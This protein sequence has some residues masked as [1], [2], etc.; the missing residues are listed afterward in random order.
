MITY[1]KNRLSRGGAGFKGAGLL[2]WK[3]GDEGEILVLLGKRLNGVDKGRWSVP[4]GGW[5][6]L[7]G[8]SSEGYRNYHRT[9]VREAKEETGY[10]IPESDEVSRIWAIHAPFFHFEV[11]DYRVREMNAVMT[12]TPLEFSEGGWYPLTSLPEPLEWFV[13]FQLQNLKRKIE[14][15]G[16]LKD[17]S[18]M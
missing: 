5:D 2:F 8:F 15:R 7:D 14:R 12:L 6:K 4:G 11:F 9:A 17:S 13:P 18:I 16:L 1:I 3:Q 10:A